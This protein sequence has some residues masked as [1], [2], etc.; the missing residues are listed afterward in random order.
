MLI[1]PPPR[2]RISRVNPLIVIALLCDFL[3]IN[4]N[5]YK[6]SS[7]VSGLCLFKMFALSSQPSYHAFQLTPHMPLSPLNPS[8]S[9]FNAQ[10]NTPYKRTDATSSLK[11]PGLFKSSRVSQRP[12]LARHDPLKERAKRRSQFLSRIK[13]KGDEKRFEARN[14]QVCLKPDISS[15]LK[16]LTLG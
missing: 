15:G 9:A 10:C 11:K 4:I 5:L 14:E 1:P 16:R 12:S 7:I 3:C 6:V 13:E 8:A 2:L